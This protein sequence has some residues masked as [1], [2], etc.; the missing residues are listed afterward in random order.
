MIE[1]N[2]GL[3]V[4]KGYPQQ[5]RVSELYDDDDA[6]SS[7]LNSV[8]PNTFEY[9]DF[10]HRTVGDIVRSVEKL[11]AVLFVD[12]DQLSEEIASSRAQAEVYAGSKQSF[13]HVDPNVDQTHAGKVIHVDDHHLVLSLGRNA[14]IVPLTLFDQKQGIVPNANLQVNIIGGI[15]RAEVTQ[16]KQASIGR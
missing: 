14:V 10:S 11:E 7:A 9:P 1:L 2:T 16:Q 5:A 15:G 12:A 3:N 8:F 13:K 4:L 6:F